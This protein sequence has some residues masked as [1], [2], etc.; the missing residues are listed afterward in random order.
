MSCKTQTNE[1]IAVDILYN[2]TPHSNPSM[3]HEIPIKY[4]QNQSDCMQKTNSIIEILGNLNSPCATDPSSSLN[5]PNLKEDAKSSN[6]SKK[7]L[8]PHSTTT[9]NSKHKH[10]SHLSLK[11]SKPKHST[12]KDLDSTSLPTKPPTIIVGGD[13]TTR[14]C[15]LFKH[16]VGRKKNSDSDPK[17]PLNCSNDLQRGQLGDEQ[18]YRP[19]LVEQHPE[20]YSPKSHFQS[21]PIHKGILEH[22]TE[23]YS[24]LE[25]SS[26]RI[27]HSSLR[28]F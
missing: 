3:N 2:D 1:Q 12:K 16:H 10:G 21:N 8:P 23:L 28:N 4:T 15:N 17:L 13:G 26:G 5:S 19:S 18:L 22:A 7:T 24:N 27:S 6:I 20:P 14:P 25:P 9:S 11:P